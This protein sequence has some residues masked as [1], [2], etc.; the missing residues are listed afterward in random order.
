MTTLVQSLDELLELL[1][2]LAHLLQLLGEHDPAPREQPRL[3]VLVPAHLLQHLLDLLLEPPRL[4]VHDLLPQSV[5][6][7]LQHLLDPPEENHVTTV[8]IGLNTLQRTT[9]NI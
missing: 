4:P 3:G 9:Q 1:L 6:R 7:H 5:G 8:E 2:D